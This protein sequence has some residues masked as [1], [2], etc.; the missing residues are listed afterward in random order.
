[1][2]QFVR[3]QTGPLELA[4]VQ[5]TPGIWER[6]RYNIRFSADQL[7]RGVPRAIHRAQ[8]QS[9]V[10]YGG[11][12]L[13]HWNVGDIL[14]QA[15]QTVARMATAHGSA[16]THQTMGE[17]ASRSRVAVA[18]SGAWGGEPGAAPPGAFF[19]RYE[20]KGNPLVIAMLVE[21]LPGNEEAALMATLPAHFLGNGG[22]VG[23]GAIRLRNTKL[24]ALGTAHY[25]PCSRRRATT[26]RCTR[27]GWCAS[28]Q[29]RSA[30]RLLRR[31]WRATARA[32]RT[33]RSTWRTSPDTAVSAS[34]SSGSRA[35]AE[36]PSSATTAG[37]RLSTPTT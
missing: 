33:P 37:P 12:A 27:T 24:T 30:W 18:L 29:T 10:W 25:A 6:Y 36:R 17:V 4:D 9:G 16:W 20:L 1:M 7:A 15:S 31:C 8:G 21:R 3:G 34:A 13:S 26:L 2:T 32:R 5:V 22:V 11:G 14:E 28:T 19:G 35:R 23:V